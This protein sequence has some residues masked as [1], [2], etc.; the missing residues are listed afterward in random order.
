LGCNQVHVERETMAAMRCRRGPA[1][2]P[3]ATDRSV[4]PA[5]HAPRPAPS[6]N[7]ECPRREILPPRGLMSYEKGREAGSAN[8]APCP[9]VC[10][11]R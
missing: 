9:P 2:R 1:H 8:R 3:P 4:A 7:P 10:R 11:P 6:D 5:R